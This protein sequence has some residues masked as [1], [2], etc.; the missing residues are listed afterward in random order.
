MKR[1][2]IL[3]FALASATVY[4]QKAV[5]PNLNKALASL[6]EG[7]LAEAKENIDA[8]ILNEKMKED[9]KTWYYRGLIYMAIDSSSN[10]Q[11]NQLAPNA[12][13]VALEAFAEADKKG[14]KGGYF[15]QDASGMPQTKDQQ[16]GWW[17]GAHVNKAIKHYQNEDFEA[18]V[19]DFEIAAKINPND[20]TAYFYGGYAAYQGENW[21]KALENFNTYLAKGGTSIDAYNVIYQIYS[22]PKKDHEKLLPIIR[23]ARKK[24]PT[25]PE[26]PKME[27]G[28]LI[29]LNRIDEA[30][31]GLIEAIKTEPNNKILHF[32]LGYAN[33]ST[34]DVEAAKKNYEDALKID[35]S[36]F[37]AQVFL[38]KLMYADALT[39]KKQ[40]G[41]LGI[42][43]DDKKKRF[44]LDKVLVEKLKVALPYWEKAEKLNS[45]DQETLDAL[46]SIYGDLDMQDQVKRIEKKYKELGYD[47]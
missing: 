15:I 9:G 40:M 10:E 17:G 26:F 5:K 19:N 12:I 30:K 23:E 22:G 21:D 18:A 46:Y 35:P 24:Y 29:E 27:I 28:A 47:N 41:Q 6:N 4:A 31:A 16:I 14:K 25:N 45:T 36:Y 13:D 34:N 7:K 42:S 3:L 39:I 44:E 2:V 37:D 32:Y 8:A 43:A 11:I 38:A 33:A 20:T 1:F